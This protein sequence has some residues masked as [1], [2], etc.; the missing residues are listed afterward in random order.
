[1]NLFKTETHFIK[2]LIV[3]VFMVSVIFF[4]NRVFAGVVS[5]ETIENAII[6]QIKSQFNE[7]GA[8]LEVSVNRVTDIDIL[9]EE[10]PEIKVEP[11]SEAF[12]RRTV[13]VVVKVIGLDG[14]EIRKIRLTAR[15]RI[16]REVV[17]AAKIIKRGEKLTK[18][19][20]LIKKADVTGLEL[21]YRS[22]EEIEGLEAI[23]DIRSGT[24]FSSLNIRPQYIVKRG[25]KVAV[26]VKSGGIFI[27]AE[28]I[29][30]ENGIKGGD[31]KVYITMTK[32]VLKCRVI[33]SETVTAGS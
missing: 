7:G 15:I 3:A 32:T 27:R 4:G 1:M 13:P 30:R 24:V 5:S 23:T 9:N 22:Q 2:S 21:F 8:E 17:S 33:D 14:G 12:S 19:N 29:A 20:V 28:G 16:F 10:N 26:E 18:E 11:V 6:S 31:I 25:D